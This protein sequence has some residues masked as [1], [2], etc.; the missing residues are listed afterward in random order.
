M[1]TFFISQNRGNE[2]KIGNDFL[3]TNIVQRLRGLNGRNIWAGREIY[4]TY[5]STEVLL[6]NYFTFSSL[7]GNFDGSYD[8]IIAGV[9]SLL[10]AEVESFTSASVPITKIEACWA[11]NINLVQDYF[12]DASAKFQTIIDNGP[13]G[14]GALI[15]PVQDRRMQN[16]LKYERNFATCKFE[17]MCIFRYVK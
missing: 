4:K 12:D 5:K 3:R 13:S 11:S 1:V 7:R 9:I 15:D 14:I 6:D 2:F 16:F 10:R 17:W 8:N